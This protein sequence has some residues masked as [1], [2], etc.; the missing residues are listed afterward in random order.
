MGGM[1]GGYGGFGGVVGGVGGGY[2]V[3][4]RI[5]VPLSIPIVAGSAGPPGMP[6]PHGPPGAPGC[7]GPPG[8]PGCP[9]PHGPPGPN[10]PPVC[11]H[12]CISI[13]P[14]HCCHGSYGKKS[15]IHHAKKH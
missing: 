3:I 15:K 7:Q 13:C 14:S 8:S 6:G 4:G 5:T 12:Q 10:C 11:T 1:G 9:G 2:H